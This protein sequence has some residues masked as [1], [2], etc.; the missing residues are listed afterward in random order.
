MEDYTRPAGMSGLPEGYRPYGKGYMTGGGFVPS[1]PRPPTPIPPQTQAPAPMPTTPMPF[2]SFDIWYYRTYGK[3]PMRVKGRY[4]NEDIIAYNIENRM[5]EQ[6]LQHER[7][8]R[9]P[10]G[11][12]PPGGMAGRPPT[13]Y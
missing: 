7:Q 1:L 4:K 10:P 11:W 3:A 13:G 9:E 12:T 2:P 5:Y 8:L 6:Q